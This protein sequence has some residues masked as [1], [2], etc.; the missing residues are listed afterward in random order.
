M[1][2]LSASKPSVVDASDSL[3]WLVHDSGCTE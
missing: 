2:R 3:T 1:A